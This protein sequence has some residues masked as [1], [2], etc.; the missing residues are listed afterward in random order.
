MGV[1]WSPYVKLLSMASVC[2]ISEFL[3]PLCQL[4]SWSAEEKDCRWPEAEVVRGAGG[5]GIFGLAITFDTLRKTI[6]PPPPP[7][8]PVNI[9]KLTQLNFFF[10]FF[11]FCIFSTSDRIYQMC[12]CCRKLENLQNW[13][14]VGGRALWLDKTDLSDQICQWESTASHGLPNFGLSRTRPPNICHVIC[15]FRS[16][17][18]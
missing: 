4:V 2:G 12:Y 16:D 11:F 18:P 1:D 13:E 17:V 6:W 9:V 8:T 3:F 10:F 15:L 14:A 7:P 5:G